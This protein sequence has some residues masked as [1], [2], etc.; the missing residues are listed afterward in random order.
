MTRNGLPADYPQM[1]ENQKPLQARMEAA[2]RVRIVSPGTDLSFRIK[3]IPVVPCAG[4]RNIPDGEIF[5]APV[6]DSVNG[7]ITYNT[8]TRYQGVVFDQIRFEFKDGRIEHAECANG[9]NERLNEVLDSDEGAR[10][11]GE[12]S[13][14]LNNEVREPM[15]DTLFGLLLSASLREP[16]ESPL[17]ASSSAAPDTSEAPLL[18]VLLS[19]VHADSALYRTAC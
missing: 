18:E 2:D 4:G 14:G 17:G 8:A 19:A 10:Y 15:L 3:D 6:R 16:K 9:Q 5:T 13:L 7:V 12:W 1:A 11:I